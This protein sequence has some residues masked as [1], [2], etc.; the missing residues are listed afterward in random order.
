MFEL[1]E[2]LVF[3]LSYAGLVVTSWVLT[4]TSFE[5]KSVFMN[6]FK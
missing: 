5:Q 1:S 2:V 4:L 3:C 6:K